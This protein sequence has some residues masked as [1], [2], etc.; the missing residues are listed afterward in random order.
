MNQGRLFTFGC[1]MTKSFYPTWADILGREWEY[2]ENWA[3]SGVG[4]G[5]IFNSIIECDHRHHFTPLDTVLIMWTAMAGR[6]DYYQHGRWNTKHNAYPEEFD[7]AESTFNCP[8]GH[9]LINYAQICAVH[10]YLDNKK[11][12]YQSM[13]WYQIDRNTEVA[14]LYQSTVDKIQHV[15]FTPNK[16]YYKP[17]TDDFPTFLQTAARLYQDLSTD[18]WPSLD[19]ILNDQFHVQDTDIENRIRN[20]QKILSVQ[21][22]L[23]DQ[24]CQRDQVEIDRHPLPT[25]HLAA[26]KSIFPNIEL[27]SDTEQWCTDIEKLV[28]AGLPT[29]FKTQFPRERL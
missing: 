17:P 19:S 13:T 26:V 2:H 22:M 15:K 1:S 23:Y 28:L 6:H 21:K 4:N 16:I 12:N 10:G 11:T 25:Q 3:Q 18:Q 9:E 14:R 8:T 7:S 27:R 20:F 24:N 5:F 29:N